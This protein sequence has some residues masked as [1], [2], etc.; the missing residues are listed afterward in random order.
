MALI[1]GRNE[2]GEG[3]GEVRE[4][5]GLER[6]ER[7]D[8][9]FFFIKFLNFYFCGGGWGWEVDILPI[10][11]YSHGLRQHGSNATA[12]PIHE[13]GPGPRPNSHTSKATALPKR[14]QG[15]GP[16]IY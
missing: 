4:D 13:Q 12:L 16:A 14:G 9:N 3:I 7:V 11:E 2:G 1:T 8:Y 15:H 6:R 5:E 10:R